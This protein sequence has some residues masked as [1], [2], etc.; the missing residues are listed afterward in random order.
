MLPLLPQNDPILKVRRTALERARTEYIYDRSTADLLFAEKVPKRDQ[1]G[2]RYWAEL[3]K[4]NLD[5]S[6]NKARIA[7]PDEVAEGVRSKLAAH[8]AKIRPGHVREATTKLFADAGKVDTQYPVE[9][10]EDFDRA[11]THLPE[12]AGKDRWD[13]DEFFAWVAIAG[14]N[15][16]LIQRLDAVQDKLLLT[17]EAY[18]RT[19]PK[20]ALE[21]ALAEGRVFVADYKDL[22]GASQG[23]VDEYTKYVMAPIAVYAAFD[24]GWTLVG[25]QTGQDPA[26]ARFVQPSDGNSWRM[27]KVALTAADSQLTGL[28]GHFGLCHVVMEAV[29]LANKRNLASN[30]PLRLLLDAHTENTLIVNEIT[31]NSLTPVG[32]TID[33]MMGQ[34]L[35]DSLDLTARSVRAFRLMESAPHEDYA[36]RGVD[37]TAAL[38]VYPYRDDQLLLWQALEPWIEAYVRLYYSTDADVFLDEELQAFV[39]ELEHEHLGGLAGIGHIETIERLVHLMSRIVF[40]ATAFHAAINYA[41]YDFGYAPLQPQAQF[42]PGPSGDDTEADFLAMLPPFDVAYE[43][44]EAFHPLSVRINQLGHY[45]KAFIDPRVEGLVETLQEELGRIEAEI[46]RR[47]TTR[48]APY[49]YCLPSRVSNSIHV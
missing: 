30:H 3:A 5:V 18:Q 48:F 45:G 20:D 11:Y 12:P 41:L 38:P 47:N 35:E 31:R 29:T 9:R 8:A 24:G 26:T 40:R 42:A 6:V 23:S 25:I 19:L 34:T 22:A 33:R 2:A 39:A 21:T 13:D 46:E 4:V 16:T 36:R 37:D 10:P 7:R 44:I 28:V 14:S 15:P 32:G 1:G 49:P 17:N 43:V 27:A